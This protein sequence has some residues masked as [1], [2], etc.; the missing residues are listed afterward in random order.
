LRQLAGAFAALLATG[1]MAS[2]VDTAP[3]SFAALPGFAA[4]D[5]LAALRAFRASCGAPA[6]L[7]PA[8]PPPPALA[9]VCAK[10]LALQPT[11]TSAR[12]FFER[13]FEPR[14]V[15]SRGDAF[16]TGYY[17]P[18]VNGSLV[19]TKDYATPLYAPPPD[20]VAVPPGATHQG[21]DP[22]LSAARRQPDGH[23]V[24]M[25]DRAAVETG[26]IREMPLV[27]LRDPVEAFFVQV[28]GSA[29]IAL[30]DGSLRRLVYAGRNGYP[31]TS[32]GKLLVDRLHIPPSQM[33]MAQLKAWIR[34]KGQGSGD[35]GTALMR[36]NRS[37]IFFAFDDTLPPEAGPIGGE[38]VSLSPLRSLAIDRAAW[39]YGLPFYLDAD[40][41][42]EA[43]GATPLRR[44]MIGQDTGSAIVGAARGDIFFGTGDEAARRAGAL[45][46]HGT[47]YVLWPKPDATQPAV[48]AR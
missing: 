26:A 30:P 10:A 12:A 47:L 34:A 19:A 2:A 18:V 6:A 16:F 46:D 22:A 3:A 4:D 38:G 42:W 37:Y 7:R 1:G 36:E 41:P 39:P 44:L 29:R 27:Y 15:G 20:L 13:N 21:L 8:L 9:A 35:E 5:H 43:A 11:A 24:P 40:L 45:R 33:G 28:Q 31:Y 32:I 25:P 48:K 14:R 23:L 17:E